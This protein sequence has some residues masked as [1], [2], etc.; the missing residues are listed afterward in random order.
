MKA[1]KR[2][3]SKEVADALNN[4]FTELKFKAKT[5]QSDA[6]M[7]FEGDCKEVYKK[8]NVKHFRTAEITQKASLTERSILVSK[9][10]I[11]KHLA[12]KKSF[13]W[14]ETLNDVKEAYNESYNRILKMSPN[15]AFK[16]ENQ[17]KIFYNTVTT[18]ENNALAKAKEQFAYNINQC[19]RILLQQSFG[20]SYLGNYSQVIYVI[21]DRFMSAGHVEKYRIKEFFTNENLWGSWYKQELA[22]INIVFSKATKKIE[23][24]YSFRLD[25]NIEYVQL[26]YYG[27][28]RKYWKK[29]SD[30]LETAN[31]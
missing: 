5:I 8:H 23:K 7:E 27:D 29:Y 28:K 19:V 4:F 22:P 17:S 3:L 12:Y 9:K 15:S 16:R 30:L 11:F 25:N 2:K 18:R 1:L 6:G 21:Y 14:I 26:S 31:I 10:L 24:I 20:K 13:R